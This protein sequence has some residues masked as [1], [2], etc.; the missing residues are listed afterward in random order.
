[1]FHNNELS[2]FNAQ[3]RT[4]ACLLQT[5]STRLPPTIDA[6]YHEKNSFSLP[7]HC[8]KYCPINLETLYGRVGS[9]SDHNEVG[10]QTLPFSLRYFPPRKK[11]GLQYS[12][13]ILPCTDC[14]ILF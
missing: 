2:N 9:D 13:K 11:I 3:L 10:Q 1:M 5:V 7:V 4:R 12:C 8:T 14:H 6:Y